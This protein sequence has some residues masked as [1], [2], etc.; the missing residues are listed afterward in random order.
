VGDEVRDAEAAREAGIG[1]AAVA[2]GY[3][4]EGTLAAARPV[5]LFREVSEIP[6]F[7][8]GAS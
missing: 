5:A 8:L 3:A 4:A 1:F 6:A 7:L 2:W